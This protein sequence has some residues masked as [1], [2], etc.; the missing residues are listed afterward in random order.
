[1]TMTREFLVSYGRAAHLGRFAFDAQVDRGTRVV[2]RSTRGLEIGNILGPAK[3]ALPDPHLGEIVRIA[4]SID[5]TSAIEREV[6]AQRLCNVAA[7]A[8]PITVL[9]AEVTLDGRG[10]VVH[11]LANGLDAGPLLDQLAE[12][13]NM[14]VRLYDLSAE[15]PA[16][17]PATDHEEGFKCDKP[18]CGE[19]ECKDC[20]TGGGCSSC[21]AGS[22]EDLWAYFAELRQKMEEN[23]RLSLH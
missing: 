12:Q 20:S 9:D 16:P 15:S 8:S 1:M 4:S 3:H 13:F 19:G 14:I 22:K 6:Q 21:S 10:A 2:I 18:D 7:G 17:S 11:A 23:S 5:E